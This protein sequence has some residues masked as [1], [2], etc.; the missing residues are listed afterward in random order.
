MA[1]VNITAAKMLDVAGVISLQ[2]LAAASMVSFAI[3]YAALP[4]MRY[5]YNSTIDSLPG[6]YILL[7]SGILA[8]ASALNFALF[9]QKSKFK[10]VEEPG[11]GQQSL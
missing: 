7:A 9:S 10:T 8:L 3:P 11:N 5:L 1:K 2:I 6:A 4:T